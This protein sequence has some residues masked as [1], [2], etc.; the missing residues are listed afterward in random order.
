MVLDSSYSV[1]ASRIAFKKYCMMIQHEKGFRLECKQEESYL[2][3]ESNPKLFW[4]S[5]E[6]K[7]DSILPF[8]PQE[9]V[10]YYTKIYTS[11]QY[12]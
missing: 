4:K 10:D 9:V 1:G 11:R 3:L 2:L 6:E 5:F 8:T 12:R 7:D